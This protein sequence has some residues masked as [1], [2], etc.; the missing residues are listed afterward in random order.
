LRVSGNGCRREYLNLKESNRTVNG[1][2]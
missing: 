2:T 1:I